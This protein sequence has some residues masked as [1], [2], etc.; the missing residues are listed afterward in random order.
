MEGTTAM[1]FQTAMKSAFVI[2][3]LCLFPFCKAEAANHFRDVPAD[4]WAYDVLDELKSHGIVQGFGD[5]SYRG[6]RNMT[7]YEMA[8]ITARAM[9]CATDIRDK[10]FVVPA[11]TIQP[12]VENAIKHGVRIREHGVVEVTTKEEGNYHV[13]TVKDN[14]KGFDVNNRKCGDEHIGIDNVKS[15]I[16]RLLNGSFMIESEIGKGTTVTIKI[17]KT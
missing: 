8:Q 10:D 14:G 16:E 6:N 9:A 5:N 15:R 11:L 2:Y 13:I 4:H 17:P 1:N 7:R 12:M 3:L